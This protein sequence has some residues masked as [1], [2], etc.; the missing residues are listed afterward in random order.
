MK[1][2]KHIG[3]QAANDALEQVFRH[4]SVRARPPQ[5]AEQ[6]VRAALHSEW[7][8]MTGRRKRRRLVFSLAAAASVVLAVAIATLLPRGP[9]AVVPSVTLATV[10]V[11]TGVVLLHTQDEAEPSRLP[12]ST[13]LHSGARI[14]TRADS[15]MAVRWA[16][17]SSVRLDQNSAVQ[18]TASG[19]IQ[20][21]AGRLYV[22]TQDSIDAAETFVVLT[23]A[24]KVRH[25]GTQ[26]M[27]ALDNAGTTISV[28]QGRVRIDGPA[29]LAEAGAGEQLR[30][31]P[32]GSSTRRVIPV[33]GDLWQ[34]TQAVAPAFSSD[35]RTVA[36]FLDWVSHESGRSIR[37]ASPE[38]SR[39]AQ[40]V[41][42]RGQIDM[43]PMRALAVVLPTSDLF[44][45]VDEGALVI[46]PAGDR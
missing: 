26:Y 6:A 4:A 37:Y 34:W 3:D 8:A 13:T 38:A 22:D 16:D 42:L 28:R 35:G 31:D 25:L 21:L 23:P 9:A 30:V 1:G 36:D 2:T 40:Q 17:G 46:Y 14:S 27:T 19:D 18:L 11:A 5:A 43:E 12:A 7:S 24:G 10:E 20:L 45:E 15:G 29:A 33:Y 32:A 41:Q 44:F 39:M